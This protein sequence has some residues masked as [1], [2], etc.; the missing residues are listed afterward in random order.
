M[1]KTSGQSEKTKGDDLRAVPAVAYFAPLFPSVQRVPLFPPT[2]PVEAGYSLF[3]PPSLFSA[4]FEMYAV[5][6]TLITPV[7]GRV[8]GPD[9]HAGGFRLACTVAPPSATRKNAPPQGDSAI[10]L[11]DCRGTSCPTSQEARHDVVSDYER[12]RYSTRSSPRGTGD[13]GSAADGARCV[14]TPSTRRSDEPSACGPS[15]A[16]ADPQLHLHW[17][18]FIFA[19]SGSSISPAESRTVRADARTPSQIRT[20]SSIHRRKRSC[21]SYDEVRRVWTSSIESATREHTAPLR[22]SYPT[23]P[24]PDLTFPDDSYR[25]RAVANE[26]PGKSRLR[27]PCPDHD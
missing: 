15:D 24:R 25:D 4:L 18:M 2:L 7:F 6:A 22:R 19:G 21:R 27:L 14:E 20:M 8:C 16:E 9:G 13:C 23:R 3:Y 10:V 5:G 11:E 12:A 26:K 17:K 1:G